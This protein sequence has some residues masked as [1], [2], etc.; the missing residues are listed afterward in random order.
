MTLHNALVT[1]VGSSPASVMIRAR[2]RRRIDGLPVAKFM[3]AKLVIA[4]TNDER[5]ARS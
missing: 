3:G 2:A 5:R 4:P 1:A